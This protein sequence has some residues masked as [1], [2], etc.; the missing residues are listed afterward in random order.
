MI[1]KPMIYKKIIEILR[2][3]KAIGKNKEHSQWFAYRWIDDIYNELHW[4]FA[5]AGVFIT[6]EVMKTTREQKTSK[7]WW[8]LLYTIL[9]MQFTFRAEDWSSVSSTICGEAMDS[10]DKSC[11]KSMSIALKYALMQMFLIP[12]KDLIDSD[13]E[14]HT[15]AEVKIKETFTEDLFCRLAIKKEAYQN[16]DEAISSIMKTHEITEVIKEKIKTLY[17]TPEQN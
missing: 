13:S 1:D 5:D 7:N 12:T 11:N 2:T 10:G 17:Q 14:I 3:T 15:L 16:A 8:Q 6:S 4:L 9:D